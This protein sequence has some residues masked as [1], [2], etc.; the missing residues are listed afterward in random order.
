MALKGKVWINN[1]VI[2]KKNKGNENS[3]GFALCVSC[4]LAAARCHARRTKRASQD[5][6]WK[7]MCHDW[8]P[9]RV[10]SS[11]GRRSQCPYDNTPSSIG[12]LSF[13]FINKI[14]SFR[15]SPEAGLW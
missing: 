11:Q 1:K 7:H 10:L 4:A 8:G 12:T 2:R 15:N 6:P 3:S 9:F 14:V 13:H 5:A